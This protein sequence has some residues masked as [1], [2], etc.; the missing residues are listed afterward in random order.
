MY[1]VIKDY[2]HERATEKGYKPAKLIC[3]TL[4]HIIAKDSF[5]TFFSTYIHE[6]MANLTANITFTLSLFEDIASREPAARSDVMNALE[7]FARG[8]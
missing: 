5:L 1:L 4:D 7:G 6:N 8:Q 2:G 3:D